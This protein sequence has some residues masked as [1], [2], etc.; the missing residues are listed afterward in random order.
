MGF[1]LVGEITDV[2]TIARGTGVRERPRLRRIYGQGKWRKV[3]GIAKIRLA[4]GRLRWA[5]LHWCEARGIGR[6]EFKR[7]RYLD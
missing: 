6:K 1:E 5:E 7:K 3:K 4:S 2:Q